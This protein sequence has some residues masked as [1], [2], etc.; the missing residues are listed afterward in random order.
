MWPG[1]DLETL[2]GD[3]GDSMKRIS[4]IPA[5]A[6]LG[7]SAAPLIPTQSKPHEIV[8]FKIP[9]QTMAV[10]PMPEQASQMASIS[11]E[12]VEPTTTPTPQPAIASRP[13][14]GSWQDWFRAA[15]VA[16][17][18][19]PAAYAIMMKESGGRPDAVNK[20][21]GSCGL[22]QQLPCGKWPHHWNDPVGA[23]IDAS[24]YAQRRYGGW[25]SAWIA[26][27]RQGWW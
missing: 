23:V 21:S 27:G 8:Y 24:S 6:I 20:S 4:L 22:F 26:W 9:H 25:Q 1:S 17:S 16:E 11:S 3:T 5:L 19:W 15:G 2:A 13:V 18:D 12:H 14:S 7:L 10:S